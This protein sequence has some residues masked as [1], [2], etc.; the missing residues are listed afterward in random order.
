MKK[1]FSVILIL[2]LAMSLVACGNKEEGGEGG[3][4]KK[5]M[6]LAIVYTALGDFWDIC[7]SGGKKRVEELKTEYPEWDIELECT[8]AS[9]FG[10]TAQIQV[11][12]NLISL[13]YDGMCV[14]AAD[15][16]GMTPTLNA[17]VDAG[18]FVVCMDTDCPDSKRAMF[19]GTHNENFGRKLAQ[20]AVDWMDGN[21]KVILNHGAIAQLGMIQRL[22]GITDVLNEN[23]SKG[24]E[25]LEYQSGVSGGP[26]GQALCEQ[27]MLSHPDW[28]TTMCDNAGGNVV[29]AVWEENGWNDAP[30]VKTRCSVLSDD[31]P[32]V[33]NAI[34]DKLATATL[35]QKQANWAYYGVDYMFKKIA[36]GQ[37]PDTDFYETPTFYV[38]LENVFDED[39][40]PNRS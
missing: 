22:K 15:A 7:G 11:L 23:A 40:Y 33:I 24:A 31:A 13:G 32:Q 37:D 6:K 27:M 19:V 20:Y 14:A 9:E 3:G 21:A 25:L 35:V 5:T 26:D 1:L 34:K 18:I 10:I 2:V 29:A 8:A 30:D 16:E 12:E 4:E 39:M 28:N 17:A 36:L 38:T